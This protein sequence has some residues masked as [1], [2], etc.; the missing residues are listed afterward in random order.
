MLRYFI[1]GLLC[2]F[3]SLCLPQSAAAQELARGFDGS[4]ALKLAQP[5]Q[6]QVLPE[7]AIS[8]PLDFSDP[9]KAFG[10]KDLA[11]GT[12]LPTAN[13]QAVWMRFALPVT[14]VGQTWYL[15]IPRLRLAQVTLYFLDEQNQWKSQAAG[16]NIAVNQWPLPTRLPSF[17]LATHTDR[18]QAYFVKLEHPSSIAEHPELVA[19]IDYIVSASQTGSLVGLIL[20]LFGL[21]TLLSLLT[22]RLYRNTHFVWFALFV[23]SLLAMQLVLMGFAG[24]HIWPASAYLNQIMFWVSSLWSLAACL[25]FILQVS[26]AK[27]AFIRLYQICLGVIALLLACSAAVAIMGQNFPRSG[28]TLFV[29][30]VIV[31]SLGSLLWMAWRAQ[32]WLWVVAAGFAPL[33]LA[34]STRLAY[35]FGWVAHIEV[36]QFW[37]VMAGIIG[38]MVIYAGLILRNRETF[39]ALQRQAALSH[40]DLATGLTAAH[41]VT[42]RL[43]RVMARSARSGDTCGVVMLQ[44]MELQKQL[45]PLPATQKDAVL[46]QL[47]TRLRRLSR[48]IDTVARL[49]DDHFLFIVESPITRDY[50]NA[51]A[52]KMLTAC[53]RPVDQLKN[54]A[55]FNVHIAL[56]TNADKPMTAEA[57]L[58]AL[59]TR[60]HQM[61]HGTKRKV[62]FVD[63]PMSSRMDD[64]S[65]ED[66]AQAPR[67]QDVLAKINAIET[68][69]L[70][71]KTVLPK[72]TP[73]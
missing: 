71:L 9:A 25:W 36:T 28:L 57:V 49:D 42:T 2:L 26:Y 23:F 54:G 11:S 46:A 48:Y 5:L 65:A 72:L 55:A 22:A 50:L 73:S 59:R 34:M 43:P 27:Q 66:D 16:L 8:S 56:W 29:A 33:A 41:M 62:Q 64:A 47:G 13:G 6:W 4:S 40:T 14:A 7:G 12:T 70:A 51:L 20:G 38:T 45:G 10:F 63:A 19:P 69:A 18:S 52:T 1:S 60:L 30:P 32:P 24:Q 21:L 44:W 61:E 39:A 67:G 17:Q 68:D 3:A 15:R 37:S 53:M 31:W 35:N 58:E